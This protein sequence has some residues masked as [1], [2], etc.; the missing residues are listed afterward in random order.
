[1]PQHTTILTSPTGRLRLIPPRP[2]DDEASAIL[3]AHPVS[4][5]YL[6]FMPDKV[7]A[8]DTRKRREERAENVE[9]VDFHAHVVNADG[10]TTFAGMTGIFHVDP[11]HESFEVGILISPDM[12]RGGFATEAIYTVLKY[13]FEDRK[14]H[15][16]TFETSEDNLPMRSW[17]E[18][19]LGAKL[20]GERREAWKEGDGKYR[21]VKSYSLLEREWTGHAKARL[22][23]SIFARVSS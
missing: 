5:K 11:T 1:M 4:L 8:E 22:E 9:I 23:K 21:D 15:R 12:H 6:R 18:N 13:A 14:L 16:G 17:L 20:E 10:T 7:T 3:R 2:E 19:V